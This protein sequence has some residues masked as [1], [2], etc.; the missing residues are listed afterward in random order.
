MNLASEISEKGTAQDIL[1]TITAVY[2]ETYRQETLRRRMKQK[3]DMALYAPFLSGIPLYLILLLL[4]TNR[5]LSIRTSVL[6]GLAA[7][8]VNMFLWLRYHMRLRREMP[9]FAL[10]SAIARRKLLLIKEAL[11]A[12]RDHSFGE[13]DLKLNL[14][15]YWNE[16]PMRRIDTVPDDIRAVMNQGRQPSGS[17]KTFAVPKGE[18]VTLPLSH[19]KTG[20]LMEMSTL[21]YR[22]RHATVV[23]SGGNSTSSGESWLDVSIESISFSGAVHEKKRYGPALHGPFEDLIYHDASPGSGR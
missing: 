11:A 17:F 7:Y 15:P 23:G 1:E 10:H 13:I 6:A 18:W 3:S 14:L 16:A 12:A 21:C 8:A 4:L 2:D 22:L 5:G 19:G 9:S 20:I